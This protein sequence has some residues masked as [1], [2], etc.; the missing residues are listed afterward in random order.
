M[1]RPRRTHVRLALH[2]IE[3]CPTYR[4]VEGTLRQLPVSLTRRLTRSAAIVAQQVFV[5][6]LYD[7][8]TFAGAFAEPFNIDKL[9]FPSTI[10]DETCLLE[11]VRNHRYARTPNTKHLGKIFL[12]K[13]K[14]VALSQVSCA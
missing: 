14:Y 3:F 6:R 7:F 1:S 13:I 11:G 12:C 5:M 4:F 8:I 2:L 10:L 9:D